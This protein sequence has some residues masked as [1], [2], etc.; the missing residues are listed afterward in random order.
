MTLAVLALVVVGAVIGGWLARSGP[1][2][3]PLG[4][5][6][7]ASFVLVGPA[8]GS[9]WLGTGQVSVLGLASGPLGRLEV[10]V[11][12]DG[13]EVGS[14]EVKADA[15]GPVSAVVPI[16]PPV[17]GGPAVLEVRRAGEDVALATVDIVLEPANQ[18]V[19]WAPQS[20]E[21]VGGP[22]FDVIGFARPPARTVLLELNAPD[23]SRVATETVDLETSSSSEV[24][25][26]WRR[27]E[28]SLPLSADAEQACLRL[29]ASAL[30]PSG[31]AL[32]GL[33]VPLTLAGAPGPGCP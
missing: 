8:P 7:V 32:F 14:I 17:D 9:N 31:H 19:V 11:L 25:A 6:Q 24:V 3:S 21:R 2:A 12:V 20:R 15:D 28:A 5:A 30:G 10:V 4:S 29:F 26:P 27:F 16:L 18:L 1:A 13:V 22:S 33:D 23:G